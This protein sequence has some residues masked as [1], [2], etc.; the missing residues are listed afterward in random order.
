M[1]KF[2][3]FCKQ[4][5]SMSYSFK[6]KVFDAVIISSLIYGCETWLNIKMKKIEKIYFDAIRALLDVRES[7]RK[8]AMLLETGMP[9]LKELIYEKTKRYT[10][11]RLN[12]EGDEEIPLRKI[13]K[14][15]KENNSRGFK[16][17]DKIISEATSQNIYRI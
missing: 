13:F 12:T 17:I 5:K 8:D 7:T 3:I 15:C 1:N 14:L 11:K 16:Y 6:K 9:S 2:R 4:N 10:K